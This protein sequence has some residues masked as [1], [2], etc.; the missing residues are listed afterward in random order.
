MLEKYIKESL[1]KIKYPKI[2]E[3]KKKYFLNE[4]ENRLLLKKIKNFINY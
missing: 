2:D 1:K 3:R 4:N